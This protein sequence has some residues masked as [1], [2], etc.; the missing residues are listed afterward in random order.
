MGLQVFGFPP[1]WKT[2]L[3]AMIFEDTLGLIRVHPFCDTFPIPIH[4]LSLLSSPN[5]F[6][7]R[8]S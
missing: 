3:L 6:V 8:V 1:F 4:A 7:F 5:L 2:Y